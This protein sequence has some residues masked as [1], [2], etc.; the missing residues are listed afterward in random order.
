MSD[1]P[2]IEVLG[3]GEEEFIGTRL[4]SIKAMYNDGNGY[5]GPVLTSPQQDFIWPTGEIKA[6]CMNKEHPAPQVDC[7]CGFY[8]I[9][10]TDKPSYKGWGVE[11]TSKDQISGEIQM[12]GIVID[13]SRGAYI[14]EFCEVTKLYVDK[15]VSSAGA[16][17]MGKVDTS[18]DPEVIKKL[19]D[20][21]K[22]EVVESKI[23]CDCTNCVEFTAEKNRRARL[24]LSRS[25]HDKII[26]EA[27]DKQAKWFAQYT[28]EWYGGLAV[29]KGD[30]A[31]IMTKIREKEGTN[32]IDTLLPTDTIK[33]S[34]TYALGSDGKK[35][36]IGFDVNGT[37]QYKLK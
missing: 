24:K 27:V 25:K 29:D 28:G 22:A 9:K 36:F 1:F 7:G 35:I 37:S 15:L 33:G 16:K 21:Y 20:Y 26:T 18:K 6:K 4:W 19:A 30:L 2:D 14:S 13:G 32:G 8:A 10:K 31:Y 23:K 11:S 12:Y 17:C 34:D 3:A 5:L